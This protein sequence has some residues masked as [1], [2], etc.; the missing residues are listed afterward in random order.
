LSKWT[1]SR[2]DEKNSKGHEKENK[3][4][5]QIVHR[6]RNLSFKHENK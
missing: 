2:G 6:I 3:F 1:K 5:K 4:I